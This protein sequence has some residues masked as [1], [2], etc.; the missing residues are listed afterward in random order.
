MRFTAVLLLAFG[1]LAACA[2]PTE[3]ET[4]STDCGIIKRDANGGASRRSEV[5][6]CA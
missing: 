1:A 3:L 2:A 5:V 4:D 6:A